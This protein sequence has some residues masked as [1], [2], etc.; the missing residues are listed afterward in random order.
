MGSYA[1]LFVNNLQLLS[2]KNEVDP[3]VMALF[4]ES[5]KVIYLDE[6]DEPSISSSNEEE[7]SEFYEDESDEER[8]VVQYTTTVS[9]VRDRLDLMGFTLPFVEAVF[10]EE[11]QERINELQKRQEEKWA[12]A[13]GIKE[14]L[15]EEVEVLENM[16]F[17]SWV[18]NFA[19]AV[20]NNLRPTHDVRNLASYAPI[21]RYMLGTTIGGL[22]GFPSYDFRV[23][24]RA[25]CEI[26][27]NDADITYDVT[28]LVEGGYIEQEDDLCLY[29]RRLLADDF[30]L[31]QK[32]VVLTEGS[33][34]KWALEASLQIL[35]PHLADYYSFMD[36]E[37]TRAPGGAVAL[38]ATVKA[39]I[40]AGIANR[41]VA[42]FDNDTAAQSA[43]RALRDVV[44][45]S[46]VAVLRYPDLEYARIYPTLG[47]TGIVPMNI[48]G[49][50]CGLELY[51][52]QDVLTGD[53]GELTPIQ[54][55]GYDDA[56]RQYQGEILNKQTIQKRFA[57]KVKRCQ[58]D[59][60]AAS[61]TDWEGMKAVLDLLRKAF[62]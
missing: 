7:E 11:L 28:D 48:N 5:D 56:I 62:N 3:T 23:S 45:P 51:F 14:R 55:R 32:I 17:S 38:V 19:Y 34:D 37:G 2:T 22:Y 8:P 44:V 25:I 20:N 57:E 12:Q 24:M 1:S 9:V 29:S 52:G 53:D 16:S 43:L 49:L 30:L 39:F 50:A 59:R 4:Q 18:E 46:N 61:S 15:Q 35:Y 54:W 36:F 42:L 6:F 40:G 58:E 47:P 41:I 27:D 31:N 26:S 13:S 60:T 21:I 33:S 10:Q